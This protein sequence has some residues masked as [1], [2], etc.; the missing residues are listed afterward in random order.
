MDLLQPHHFSPRLHNLIQGLKLQHL[1][2]LPS[3]RLKDTALPNIGLIELVSAEAFQSAYQILYTTNFHGGE[4]E[5]PDLITQRLSDDFANLRSG[6]AP[7][8]IIGLRNPAGEAIGAAQFSVLMLAGGRYAVPY[9][10]YIYVRPQNRRQDLSEVMHTMVLAVATAEAGEGRVVPFTL[11]ET[12]PPGHGAT[13]SSQTNATERTRIHARSGSRAVML[14]RRSGANVDESVISAHVQPG[15][16]HEDAPITLIWAVRPSPAMEM[17]YEIDVLGEALVAAYYRSLRDEGFPEKNIAL[18]EGM[19]EER[20]KGREFF[21]MPLAD[22]TAEM[23][24]ELPA[25]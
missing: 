7:Y 15:L 17:Q 10:Q 4:R 3:S 25:N 16:E 13:Q 2:R 9:L 21:E 12:E 18:A 23:Y 8:R 5:R 24:R 1:S 22:V 20:V 6:L 14:R 19:V 11:F